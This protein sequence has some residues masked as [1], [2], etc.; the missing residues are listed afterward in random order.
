M[1]DG[2]WMD[3]Y[4]QS[5][6]IHATLYGDGG[7]GQLTI[8]G[9]G[10]YRIEIRNTRLIDSLGIVVQIEA[11]GDECKIPYAFQLDEGLPRGNQGSNHVYEET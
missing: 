9:P 1:G 11:F 7:A 5:L 3:S 8:F 10:E 4:V 6:R 2:S